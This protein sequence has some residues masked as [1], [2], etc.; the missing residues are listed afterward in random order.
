MD[1]M[2][3]LT[4]IASLIFVISLIVLLSY[5]LRRWAPTLDRF[6]MSP[7]RRLN[8][9]ES[10]MVDAKTRVLLIQRDEV[11]HLV[12]T[13]PQ[14]TTVI[15]NGIKATPEGGAGTASKAPSRASGKT[16]GKLRKSLKS[17]PKKRK[18]AA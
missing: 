14:A 3:V 13:S 15:E 2:Q 5:A 16:S 18:K 7:D 4:F 12:I 8:V 11:Q 10:L 9:V 1:L 17:G 6:K